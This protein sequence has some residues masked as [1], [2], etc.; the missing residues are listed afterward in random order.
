VLAIEGLLY[1]VIFHAARSELRKSCT[2]DTTGRNHVFPI[3]YALK[4]QID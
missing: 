4:S 2:D 3:D 1:R